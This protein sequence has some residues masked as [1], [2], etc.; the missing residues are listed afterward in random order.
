VRE[1]AGE[2]ERASESHFYSIVAG[3]R[4]RSCDW[5]L[6]TGTRLK[7]GSGVKSQAVA[8]IGSTTATG[9]PS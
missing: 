9:G 5:V 4:L 6:S 7:I 2:G 8:E 3:T 1:A